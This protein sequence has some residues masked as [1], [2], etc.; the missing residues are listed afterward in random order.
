MEYFRCLFR[1]RI[2]F[3][4]FPLVPS[5]HF[6]EA[7]YSENENSSLSENCLDPSRF[8]RRSFSLERIASDF[9]P[10]IIRPGSEMIG[11]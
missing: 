2:I 4:E 10:L 9:V 8:F 7:A 6:E 5:A 3:F 11:E 1:V